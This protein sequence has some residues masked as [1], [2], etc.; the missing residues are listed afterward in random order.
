MLIDY[1][2]RL[3]QQTLKAWDSRRLSV[4]YRPQIKD[5]I[6]GYPRQITSNALYR[7][8]STRME[9]TYSIISHRCPRRMAAVAN[10]QRVS[11]TTFGESQPSAVFG[12][13]TEPCLAVSKP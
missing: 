9:G 2:T 4:E 3:Q 13:I 1:A 6:C 5:L 7:L 10:G 11:D 12:T 8:P